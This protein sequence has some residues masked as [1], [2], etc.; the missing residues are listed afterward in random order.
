MSELCFPNTIPL[1]KR[2]SPKTLFWTLLFPLALHPEPCITPS[3]A[4]FPL[5]PFQ[6]I[7]YHRGAHSHCFPQQPQ[8]GDVVGGEGVGGKSATEG[9]DPLKYPGKMQNT[10]S[11]RSPDSHAYHGQAAT[12]LEVTYR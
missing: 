10:S 2:I 4:P 6:N 7:P 3:L 9:T 12:V 11:I 5:Q 8:N 1:L